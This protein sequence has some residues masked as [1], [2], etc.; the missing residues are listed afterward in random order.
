MKLLT[1]GFSG[2]A[3]TAL[4]YILLGT[5]ATAIAT[6]GLADIVSKKLSKIIGTTS[7]HD[8]PDCLP[9]SEPH[10]HSHRLYPHP[11]SSHARADEQ[12][13]PRPPRCGLLPCLRS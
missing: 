13:A 3:T 7:R 11:D 4:A 6:T 9:V 1:S 10:P 2:N 12:D 5:F 8:H